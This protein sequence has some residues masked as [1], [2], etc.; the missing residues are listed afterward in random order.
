[1]GV[2]FCFVLRELK[3]LEIHYMFI[4][5]GVTDSDEPLTIDTRKQTFK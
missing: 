4:I 3:V 1:M 2:E 5:L